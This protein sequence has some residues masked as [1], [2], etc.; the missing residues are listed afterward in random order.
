MIYARF[1]LPGGGAFWT[2][3]EKI[4][5]TTA[6]VLANN[7]DEIDPNRRELI[8]MQIRLAAHQLLTAPGMGNC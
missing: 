1:D 7:Q 4:G 2:L 5:A 3:P 6:D 8:S